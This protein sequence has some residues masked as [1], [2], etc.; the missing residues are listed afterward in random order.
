MMTCLT[1]GLTTG[2][3]IHLT[4]LT[5]VFPWFFFSTHSFTLLYKYIIVALNLSKHGEK[6]FINYI[7]VMLYIMLQ[8][9]QTFER[10]IQQK[11]IAKIGRNKF[12]KLTDKDNNKKNENPQLCPSKLSPKI[13]NMAKCSPTKKTKSPQNKKSQSPASIKAD[14]PSNKKAKSPKS[15]AMTKDSTQN[16]AKVSTGSKRKSSNRK[17]Q[18]KSVKNSTKTVSKTQSSKHNLAYHVKK[19]ATSHFII[20]RDF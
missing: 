11:Y 18:V 4:T 10:L 2:F 1:T 9:T 5:P 20:I 12:A 14:T 13:E 3:N 7:D 19:F 15:P 8:I 6:T 17:T 16:L